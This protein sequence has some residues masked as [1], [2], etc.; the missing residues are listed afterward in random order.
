MTECDKLQILYLNSHI[1]LFNLFKYMIKLIKYNKKMAD[2]TLLLL[3]YKYTS[4]Q[5]I[6]K[7][8]HYFS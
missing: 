4:L 3:A 2:T 5:I 7:G 8:R 1:E 6:K